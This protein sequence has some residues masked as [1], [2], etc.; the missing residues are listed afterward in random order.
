[1]TVEYR[2]KEVDQ[3][4]QQILELSNYKTILF[5]GDL[6]SGKTTLIKALVKSLGSEDYVSS[7]TFSLLNEYKTEDGETIY[8]MDLYRLKNEI[9]AFDMGLEEILENDSWKFIEWPDKINSLLGTD[10]H[11]ATIISTKENFRHLEFN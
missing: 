3:I 4:A 5:Q 10:Y 7:P 11:S 9:E 6:G 8:H 1:M 2:L